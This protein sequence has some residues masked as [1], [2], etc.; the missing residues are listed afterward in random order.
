[1]QKTTYLECKEPVT[2]FISS[3][4][5]LCAEVGVDEEF[6]DEVLSCFTLANFTRDI[7]TSKSS[8]DFGGMRDGIPFRKC[9]LYSKSMHTM[10]NKGLRETFSLVGEGSLAPDPHG[11]QTYPRLSCT[12][13]PYANAG[14][15]TSKRFP[16][17]F[18]PRTPSSQP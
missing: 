10:K 6:S 14:G 16:D 2:E 18:I 5:W 8:V 9:Y 15:I 4:L 11:V 3:W 1:M 12:L 17:F 13:S 7:S